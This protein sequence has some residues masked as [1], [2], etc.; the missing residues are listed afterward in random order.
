MQVKRRTY[1]AFQPACHMACRLPHA[2]P[3]PCDNQGHAASLSGRRTCLRN[4]RR[5]SHPLTRG[6]PTAPHRTRS[7]PKLPYS[8]HTPATPQLLSWPMAGSLCDSAS[9][10]LC[11][12]LARSWCVWAGGPRARCSTCRSWYPRSINS[13]SPN[14]CSCQPSRSCMDHSDRCVTPRHHPHKPQPPSV[15]HPATICMA[16]GILT[17]VSQASR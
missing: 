7:A 14:S 11:P 15:P 8:S 4:P 3:L 6:S 12:C 5:S 13:R 10:Q 2:Q 1:L 16:H 17:L 9:P